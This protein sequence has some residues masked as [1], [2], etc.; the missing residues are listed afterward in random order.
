VRAVSLSERLCDGTGSANIAGFRLAQGRGE[1]GGGGATSARFD[2]AFAPR[3][4]ETSS[5]CGVVF[6]ES[7]QHVAGGMDRYQTAFV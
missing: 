5:R 6:G 4:P 7:A 3:L 1:P 2:T